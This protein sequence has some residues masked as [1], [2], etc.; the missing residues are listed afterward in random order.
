MRT[1]T[2]KIPYEIQNSIDDMMYM[3]PGFEYKI[4]VD[5]DMQDFIVKN[6]DDRTLSA[7]NSLEIGASKADFFRYLLLYKNGG[8]YLDISKILLKPLGD[9]IDSDDAIVTR[10]GNKG[11]FVQWLLIYPPNHEILRICIEKCIENIENNKKI[12]VTKLT[13]PVVYSKSVSEYL[14]DEDVYSKSDNE[15]NINRS[16]TKVR[17]FGFDY[18]GYAHYIHPFRHLLYNDCLS[19]RDEQKKKYNI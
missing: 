9:L 8:V 6:Y 13:G 3:N 15:V 7:F 2:S 10:E 1:P 4:F 17:L 14:C 18:N 5:E 19:W 11:L 12:D 16:Q